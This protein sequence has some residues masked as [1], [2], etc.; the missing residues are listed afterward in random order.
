MRRII[1]CCA[2][3]FMAMSAVASDVVMTID[4]S[5]KTVVSTNR[6]AI[7]ETVP[8]RLVGIDTFSP[9]NLVLRLTDITLTNTYALT[10]NF[11]AAGS[12]TSVAYGVTSVQVMA[13]GTMD[14]NTAELVAFYSNRVPQFSWP[15]VVGLWDVGA[16][17]LLVNDRVAIMNNPY[18]PGMPGP[19][20]I[21]MVYPALVPGL[22]PA[23]GSLLQY[24]GNGLWG[25]YNPTSLLASAG[26]AWGSIQGVITNQ[27]D[28]WSILG[29]MISGLQSATSDVAALQSALV[30]TGGHFTAALATK[31]GTGEVA[32]VQAGLTTKA[33]TGE[34]AAV[35]AGL[36]TK[37]DAGDVAALQSALVSTGGHFTAAL[38]TKAGTGEVAA[39]QADLATKANAGEVAALQG[40][41]VSTGGH[42]TAALATKAGTGE[43][44]AVQA[45]LATKANT[46]EVAALQ[47][48]LVSTGGHFT[49][50]IQTLTD[51][52]GIHWSR[53]PP[54][55]TVNYAGQLLTNVASIRTSG[56][57][58]VVS[59][60]Y[61]TETMRVEQSPGVAWSP[62]YLETFTGSNYVFSLR[63][64]GPASVATLSR[65]VFL[66]PVDFV[67]G[68]NAFNFTNFPS[69]ITSNGVTWS[70]FTGG[71]QSVFT[72]NIPN[73]S[74]QAPT[75]TVNYAGQLL[76]NLASI[77]TSGG[78]NVV[79]IGYDTETM[80]VEQSPGVAW[81]P[82]YL[83]TFTGS[84]YVF[85][86]RYMGPA[87]VAT[88]SRFVFL[89]PVDFVAGGNAFNFTNFP[90][91]ITSNGVTWSQFTG[92]VQSVFTTNIPNWSTQSATQTVDFATTNDTV[93]TVGAIPRTVPG[94]PAGTFASRMVRYSA[95]YSG[96]PQFG[97]FGA[98]PMN[99]GPSGTWPVW[100]SSDYVDYPEVTNFFY[101]SWNFSPSSYLLFAEFVSTM[102]NYPRVFNGVV[103]QGQIGVHN[104]W[105]LS[106]T[107]LWV[108]EM[109]VGPGGTTN[110]LKFEGKRNV[111]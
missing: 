33:G 95:P 46:G 1:I 59:I 48:A 76:T 74:T 71:V 72:T 11:V 14:L 64:M 73:W 106:S 32:A 94:R 63:Y 103:T 86:L 101:G 3:W 85:S 17:R 29:P 5:R 26:G 39:V 89:N 87:S 28:L 81:S 16:N 57:T 13:T 31:A 45:D 41:L 99:T 30:S 10:T 90:S 102:T 2:V 27:A 92:G 22:N 69:W 60:G 52:D 83:E 67:A 98:Y 105:F 75:Q 66:N 93:A 108:P 12:V 47:G 35:Q 38:A 15:F 18:S 37:A 43:V 50:A 70:Q 4:V 20:P 96:I 6:I 7:R 40:A 8:V 82:Y 61:D 111:F 110:W 23:F 34:V 88:L 104:V 24:I 79:S 21:G 53:R 78:T 84:N 77:R 44:A 80:R 54:T 62:Y 42:F 107:N 9:S 55:Q 91:W 65:F 51:T 68:G 58:N 100:Y 49:A 97:W 19:S 36:T 56:G 25:A 109:P